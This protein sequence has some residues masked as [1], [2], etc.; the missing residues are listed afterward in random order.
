M[1]LRDR[2]EAKHRRT[3]DVPVL[4]SDSAA[5]YEELMRLG[6][7]L[8][9]A[10]GREPEDAVAAM[11]R[12]VE[13]ATERVRDHYVMV[14]LQSLPRADWWSIMTTH[15]VDDG[16][17]WPKA[18]PVLLA[19]SAVDPDLQDEAWWAQCLAGDA[20]SEGDTAALRRAL[21]QLNV[22]A[23]DAQVPKG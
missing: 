1:S 21:L 22:D 7:A 2:L 11:E 12:E 16:T 15:E 5:A 3:V 20:W 13:A 6:A 18:L 19:A 4:V 8:G 10:R 17:D 14:R 9:V 23:P